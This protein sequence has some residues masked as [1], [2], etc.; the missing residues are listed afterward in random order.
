MFTQTAS[1][2]MCPSYTGD[3]A[4]PLQKPVDTRPASR[5]GCRHTARAR[6]QQLRGRRTFQRLVEKPT[7]LYLQTQTEALKR[8]LKLD[9]NRHDVDPD[10]YI[11]LLSENALVCSK[12]TLQYV[13]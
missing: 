10:D 12:T 2:G 8:T 13:G 4:A 3:T 7:G 1:H 5:P 6:P 9:R 11:V